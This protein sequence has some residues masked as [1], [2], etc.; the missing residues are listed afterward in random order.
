MV[1]F[2]VRENFR[3]NHDG[4]YNIGI[5]RYNNIIEMFDLLL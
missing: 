3:Q 1:Y 4:E 5:L 2:N